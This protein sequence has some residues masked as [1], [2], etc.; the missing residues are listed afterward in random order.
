MGGTPEFTVF[1]D[2]LAW[3]VLQVGTDRAI[4]KHLGLAD[5]S[6]MSKW[7]AGEGRPSELVCVKLAR[8]TNH[9]PLMV[10]RSAGY[11]EMADLLEG[12]VAPPTLQGELTHRQLDILREMVE[13]AAPK[14][15]TPKAKGKAQ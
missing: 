10:L 8:W 1:R 11:D 4:A 13:A 5:G 6:P 15:A 12:V 7:R 3:I 9:D 14:F 2:Y